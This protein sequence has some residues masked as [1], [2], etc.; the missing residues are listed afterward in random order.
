MNLVIDVGNT[1]TKIAVFSEGLP[2]FEQQIH[3]EALRE[4]VAVIC[5]RF[6]VSAGILASVGVPVTPMPAWNV[7]LQ[8]VIVLKADTP[9]PFTNKYHTPHTLG[10]DRIALAAAAVSTYPGKNVLVIDAGTCITY[11]FVNREGEYLGGAIAPGLQ[12]RYKSLP[13][14]TAGLPLV[15]H[16]LIPEDYIGTTTQSAIL[17]GVYFGLVNEINGV[18][19]EYSKRFIDLTVILTGGDMQILSIKLKSTIF[20]NPKFLLEGLN[21]ILEYNK[22]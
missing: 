17:S 3:P 16:R 14:F 9:V 12:M 11:D 22:H 5:E 13:Q 10:V 15:D 2:V 20:A 21:Y 6:P 18:I 7:S 8:K 4:T 1:F 19:A